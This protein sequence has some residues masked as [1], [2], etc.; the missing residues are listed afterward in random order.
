MAIGWNYPK[1]NLKYVKRE[2]SFFSATKDKKMSIIIAADLVP[3]KSN[4]NLFVSGDVRSLFGKEVLE[5]LSK[6]DYRICNLETPLVNQETP[7]PKCGPNLIASEASIRGIR[8]VGINLVTLANNH[9]MDQGEQGL[10]STCRVLDDASIR[11]VGAGRNLSE[12]ARPYVFEQKGKRFGVYA[13]AEHEFSIAQVNAPGANPF[14]PLES[15]EHIQELRKKCDYVIVLYHGGKEYYRYPSPWLQRVCRKFVDKGANLVLCQHSHCIGCSE[16][17]ENGTILYGQGNFLFDLGD[18]DYL[19][20]SLLV[21]IND[22]LSISFVPLCK[23]GA[24]VRLATKE[25]SDDILQQFYKRNDEIKT[26]G[27]IEN[28]YDEFANSKRSDYLIAFRGKESFVFRVI[29]KALG[30]NRIRKFF[31]KRIYDQRSRLAVLNFVECEAHREL[32]I[33]SLKVEKSRNQ[34]LNDFPNE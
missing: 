12:A 14:D 21:L 19:N 17:Y 18:D 23:N 8:D 28:N 20:S 33:R 24:N 34:R 11:Y 26:H 29:N 15:F 7:I 5:T 32:I 25:E 16:T 2:D 10:D 27:F 6:A 1:K 22:D 9:V 31:L 30:K 3:T 4:A 13:C